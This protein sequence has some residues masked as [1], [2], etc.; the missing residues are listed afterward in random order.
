[1]TPK[2]RV[3]HDMI[4]Y[5]AAKRHSKKDHS[6]PSRR[7]RR[8]EDRDTTNEIKLSLGRRAND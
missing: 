4:K 8:E 7:Q 2:R 6:E 3:H 1:M 5:I